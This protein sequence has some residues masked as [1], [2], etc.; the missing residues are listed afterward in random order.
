MNLSYARLATIVAVVVLVG[1]CSPYVTTI[2]PP[3]TDE[4]LSLMQMIAK[5][6][7]MCEQ[8]RGKENVPNMTFTTDGCSAAANDGPWR[9]CC[10]QH[11]MVYWCGG[12]AAEMRAADD[13]LRRCLTDKGYPGLLVPGLAAL[14]VAGHPLSIAPWRWGYGHDYPHWYADEK[15]KK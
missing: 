14:H 2:Q 8:R 9:S 11:D 13:N 15:P 7:Q 1:A 3:Y 4:K 12:A 10:V 6:K 5:A